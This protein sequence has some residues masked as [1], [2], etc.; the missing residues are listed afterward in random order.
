MLGAFDRRT[1]ADLGEHLDVARGFAGGEAVAA[2]MWGSPGRGPRATGPCA[3]APPPVRR[4]LL[5]EQALLCVESFLWLSSK[6]T[7]ANVF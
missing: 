7:P 1:I 6:Q 5:G 4:P 2:E 3:P